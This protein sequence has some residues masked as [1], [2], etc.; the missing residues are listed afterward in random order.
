MFPRPLIQYFNLKRRLFCENQSIFVY[1]LP[2]DFFYFEDFDWS[3]FGKIIGQKLQMS[4]PKRR[5]IKR[6]CSFIE[7][8]LL[9]QPMKQ[10]KL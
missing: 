7:G 10:R 1:G 9:L 4:L 2:I 6:C 5:R 3:F 8:A